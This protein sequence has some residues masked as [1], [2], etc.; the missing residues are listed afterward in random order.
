MQ[1][2][3]ILFPLSSHVSRILPVSLGEGVNRDPRGVTV[4]IGSRSPEYLLSRY[5][6]ANFLL[7]RIMIQQ[8]LLWDPSKLILIVDLT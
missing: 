4:V 5:L 3:A 6:L 2:T 1:I 7:F 8:V